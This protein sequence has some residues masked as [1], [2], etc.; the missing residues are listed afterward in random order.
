MVSPPEGLDVKEFSIM[1]SASEYVTG[2]E[3]G[4]VSTVSDVRQ[5]K[6][7][8]R[9]E[10]GETLRTIKAKYDNGAEIIRNPESA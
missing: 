5:A 8:D 2:I 7:F 3:A 6:R 1:T 9:K 10:A 4:A